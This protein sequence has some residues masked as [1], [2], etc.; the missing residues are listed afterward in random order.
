MAERK[1]YTLLRDRRPK[2][3]TVERELPSGAVLKFKSAFEYKDGALWDALG[4]LQAI[5]GNMRQLP[6]AL[7]KM[8][9]DPDEN[10]KII[11]NED[12]LVDA[13]LVELLQDVGEEVFGQLGTMGE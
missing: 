2:A 4:T 9:T 8:S 6:A 7:R 3:E 12:G 13:D 11:Q 5:E 10:W 1:K